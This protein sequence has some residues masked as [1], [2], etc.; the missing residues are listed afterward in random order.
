MFTGQLSSDPQRDPGQWRGGHIGAAHP[1]VGNKQRGCRAET[2]RLFNWLLISKNES[3][4]PFLIPP[5]D[6]D[7]FILTPLKNSP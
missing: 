4:L 6:A 1:A 2:L 3:A 5:S 7:T